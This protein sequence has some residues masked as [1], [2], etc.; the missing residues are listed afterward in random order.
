MQAVFEFEAQ[1]DGWPGEVRGRGHESFFLAP[2]LIPDLRVEADRFDLLFHS[3]ESGASAGEEAARGSADPDRVLRAWR[4][5]ESLVPLLQGGFA[6]LPP[7]PDLTVTFTA[8]A[9]PVIDRRERTG[10]PNLRRLIVQMLE[11]DP[12]PAYHAA[13]GGRKSFAF[14][15]F[16]L[17]VHWEADGSRIRVT[18][19]D[20]MA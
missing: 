17:D 5:G 18:A 11:N 19:I 14:R 16:D 1:L 3:G 13:K 7:A 6:P 15:I 12:R 2:P 4:A 8:A 9:E 20:E 10:I